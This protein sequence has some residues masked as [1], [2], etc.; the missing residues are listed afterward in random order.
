MRQV[1]D[2]LTPTGLF[3]LEE[4]VGPTQ[5]QWTD[6]QMNLVRALL[7]LLPVELRT[8]RW[9]ARKDTEIRMKPDELD[10][11]SPFEA[12]RSADIVPLFKQHFEVII[13]QSLGGTIQHL[14]YNSIIHNFDPDDPRA[15][16]YI[17]AIAAVEDTLIDAGL[18][19][20]DFMLLIGKP[21]G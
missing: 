9:G 18:L 5:F 20:A 21:K 4:Y 2:A 14:L 13:A 10:A 8:F 19:P 12:I 15:C 6:E 7:S 3:M 17:A 16:R 11:V 1:H